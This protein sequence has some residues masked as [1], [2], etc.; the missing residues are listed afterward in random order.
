M[1]KIIQLLLIILIIVMSLLFYNT[2][3]KKDSEKVSEKF[4]NQKTEEIEIKDQNNLIKNLKY[5]VS[6]DDSNQYILEAEESEISYESGIEIV[7]MIGVKATI[8]D[9]NNAQLVITSDFADYNNSNYNT[10]FRNNVEMT[11]LDHL[12]NSDNLNLNFTENTILIK[13]NVK[14]IGS[15]GTIITDNIV[16]DLIKKDINIYMN[17]NFK[18]VEVTKKDQN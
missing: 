18:K 13:N 5:N 6:F 10:F 8:I 3:F 14:Y 15:Q 2:Y 16:L 9:R 7:K 1:K 4:E 17:D 12:I 11:Y